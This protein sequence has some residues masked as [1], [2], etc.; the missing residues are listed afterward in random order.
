MVENLIQIKSLI[1]INVDVSAKNIM[2][3][4][5]VLF[6]ILL[7]VNKNRKFLAGIID[8]SVIMYD[9]ILDAE[10]KSN[11]EETKI[12]ATNFNEKNITCK[13]QNF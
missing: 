4:E 13:T 9:D 7:H 12:I 1:V 11:N 2:Y 8:D 5:K 3:M 10:A 6:G